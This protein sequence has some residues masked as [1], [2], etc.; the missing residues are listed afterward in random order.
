[1][2]ASISFIIMVSIIIISSI[3]IL[4]YGCKEE[5][6]QVKIREKEVKPDKDYSR[7]LIFT[8][9]EVFENTDSFTKWK[10]N[11]SDIQNQI[12]IGKCYSFRVHWFRSNFFSQYRNI[13]E[14]IEIDCE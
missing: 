14:V 7:Y 3:A 11:S 4:S 9:K 6:I 8:D 10:F 13:L 1:M 12:N 2:K 5:I